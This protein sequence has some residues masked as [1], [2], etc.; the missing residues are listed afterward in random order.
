MRF[1][2]AHH[3]ATQHDPASSKP[4]NPWAAAAADLDRARARR[5]D[6]WSLIW[7]CA[8][9]LM[10]AAGVVCVSR[11]AAPPGHARYAP[12]GQGERMAKSAVFRLSDF[13]V[14][15][16][17]A[18]LELPVPP[19]ELDACGRGVDDLVLSGWALSSFARG[20]T[21]AASDAIVL[22]SGATVFATSG[23]L[24]RY[25][26]RTLGG[27]AL[28]CVRARILRRATHGSRYISFR[29][30]RMPRL[31]ATQRAFRIR[32]YP[33]HS[34]A[35]W[36]QDAVFLASGRTLVVVSAASPVSAHDRAARLAYFRRIAQ[37][38]AT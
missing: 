27:G 14:G 34:E 16:G 33:P 8:L 12:S 15:S 25:A 18:D 5:R 20:L 21:P 22:T 13:P 30:V 24:D 3:S 36:E 23:M 4:G 29:D 38:I 7:A 17:W 26:A 10:L 32:F 37:R 1:K 35:L 9:G 28:S 2:S 31:A 6:F 11:A 19:G